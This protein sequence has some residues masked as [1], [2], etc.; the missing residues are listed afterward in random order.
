MNNIEQ[1]NN[2]GYCIVKNV[3]SPEIRDFITQYALFDEMQDFNESQD[4]NVLGPH[5][6]Y[7]DPAMETTL[8]KLQSIMEANTGLELFPTYSFYR[9]YRPGDVLKIHKDRP[10]CEI[11]ATVCFNYNYE[12]Y[13]WPIFMEGTEVKQEPGDMV[14]YKGTELKHWRDRF[15]NAQEDAWHVQ[16]FFHYVNVKGPYADFK[17]D[18]RESLG[19]VHNNENDYKPDPVKPWLFY[20]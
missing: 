10:S 15:E 4:P 14:I 19:L 12:N 9:V 7:A 5:S 18:K 17:Y 11:S 2:N 3:L 1:F 13:Q 8:I 20:K 6:K 16:G